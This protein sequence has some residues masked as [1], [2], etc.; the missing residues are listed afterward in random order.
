[1]KHVISETFASVGK[2]EDLEL[3]LQHELETH[4]KQMEL[5]STNIGTINLHP[6]SDINGANGY[7]YTLKISKLINSS[8]N[9]FLGKD[10]G[11]R[12]VLHDLEDTKKRSLAKRKKINSDFMLK[13]D[14][15]IYLSKK[16]S[17]G[18]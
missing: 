13:E 11:A 1:M 16:K 6:A 18:K 4:R 15:N 17:K 8:I 14:E 5:K 12:E 2:Q 3:R 9:D 7:N 10:S